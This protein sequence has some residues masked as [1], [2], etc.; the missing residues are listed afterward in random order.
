VWITLAA[1]VILLAT[2]LNIVAAVL[3]YT[4]GEKKIRMDYS[5]DLNSFET[6]PFQQYYKCFFTPRLDAIF[7]LI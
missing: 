6:W 7:A 4:S 5:K 1:H 2:Q 3:F